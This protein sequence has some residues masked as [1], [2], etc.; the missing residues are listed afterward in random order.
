VIVGIILYYIGAAKPAVPAPVNVVPNI[1][2]NMSTPPPPA[3]SEAPVTPTAPVATEPTPENQNTNISTEF[4]P[5]A[6][7]PS[8]LDSD[9]DGL[10]D[11]EEALYGTDPQKPDTD[12][13]G[14][15]DGTEVVNLYNPIGLA[16]VRIE[17]S[18]LVK[19]YAN[20]NYSY[21]LLYPIKWTERALDNTNQEVIF[22]SATGE[23]VQVV[24]QDNI[25]RLGL[26][27]WYRA[28]FPGITDKDIFSV[29][30]KDKTL[31][32]F[33]SPDDLTVYFAKDDSIYAISYNIGTRTDLNFKTTFEMIYRSFGFGVVQ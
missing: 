33:K 27:D 29:T 32:G 19:R 10:T 30:N 24:V 22:T 25:E 3:N 23:F 31:S 5:P 12:S 8:A 2:T 11:E 15:S 9:N 28:Q 21:S 4:V 1:N 7:L 20:P 13:D 26:L 16:P 6:K 14:Y 18:G 17:D